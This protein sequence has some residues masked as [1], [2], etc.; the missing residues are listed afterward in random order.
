MPVGEDAGGQSVLRATVRAVY[1]AGAGDI[2]KYAWVHAP[3]GR[4]RAW[5]VQW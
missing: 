5:T 3:E 2:E 4:A 1:G